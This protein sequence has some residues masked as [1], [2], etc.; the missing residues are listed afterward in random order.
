M[1]KQELL[2]DYKKQEDKICIAQILDKIEIS[3]KKDKIEY[4][5]FLDMYQ[6]SLVENFLR[7]AKIQ[8]YK[9]YGGYA[10]AERKILI[11]YP[12]KFDDNMLQKNYNKILK[13]VKI[14]LQELD[15]GKYVHRNYLGG[16]VKLGI[17]REKV[18]DILVRDNGADIITLS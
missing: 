2:K 14:S 13:I 15:R 5:D 18:G 1:N 11:I 17:K 9:L 10:E 6:V 3:S 4:T 7:K 12:E 16:I 8:N